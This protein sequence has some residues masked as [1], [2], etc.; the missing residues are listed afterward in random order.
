MLPLVRHLPGQH[1]HQD[2][3]D[4]AKRH[5]GID[6]Q[7]LTNGIA[8]GTH[9]QQQVEVDEDHQ[10]GACARRY[11]LIAQRT[12]GLSIATHAHDHRS[13]V[14]DPADEEYP[15][16]DPG[17]CGQ[18]T[19]LY[20][21][22]WTGQWCQGGYGFELVSE[23]HVTACRGEVHAIHI[24]PGRR[25]F[26]GIR[27]NDVLIDSASVNRIADYDPHSSQEQDEY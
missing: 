1:T 10:N 24:H 25:C 9:D 27:L 11:Q 2:Q 15:Q 26:F 4:H 3:E 20:G 17:Q 18:P 22:N 13:V 21:D 7:G 23:K 14:L 19:P 5:L 16:D 6:H 8:E 12:H